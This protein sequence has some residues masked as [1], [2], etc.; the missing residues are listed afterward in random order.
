MSASARGSTRDTRLVT[1]VS[2]K[3]CTLAYPLSFE[4]AA[5]AP[6]LGLTTHQFSLLN[7]A[8]AEGNQPPSY[9]LT[10]FGGETNWRQLTAAQ[11]STLTISGS[12]DTLPKAT[13]EWLSYLATTPSAPSASYTTVEAAPGWTVTAGIGGTQIGYIVSWEIALKR[14][15]KPIPAITGNQNYYQLFASA[16][17]A[18]L[19]LT[20]L[21]DYSA[22][23]LTAFGAGTTESFDLTLSDVVSGY[24]LNFHSTKSKFTSGD[25]DR[26]KEW[27][28][29]PL[30]AQLI[31]SSTDALAGG[32]SPILV[33][34][35][36]GTTTTY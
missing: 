18:T 35:A 16:L 5:K 4:H 14:N 9:T 6:V 33:T 32:V 31:P 36:N 15:V 10:D 2:G 7:N 29:V 34:V 17:D 20:V 13:V 23:W 19:K 25:L 12:A 1:A 8:P 30:E 3:K 24:A 27:V 26:S 21:E 28:E 11:L 22:T